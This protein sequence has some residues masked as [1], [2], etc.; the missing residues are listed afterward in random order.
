MN[1]SL[2]NKTTLE[3]SLKTPTSNE[4]IFPEPDK[5]KLNDEKKL[6]YAQNLSDEQKLQLAFDLLDEFDETLKGT[7]VTFGGIEYKR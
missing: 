2:N 6:N 4:K 7:S 3:K 5:K 1:P